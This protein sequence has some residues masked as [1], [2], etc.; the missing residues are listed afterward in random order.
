MGRTAVSVVFHAWYW[1]YL[2]YLNTY[3]ETQRTP[4]GVHAEGWRRRDAEREGIGRIGQEK[5]KTGMLGYN[6]SGVD[7]PH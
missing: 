2:S 6:F 5:G 4:H 3:G 1:Y 7:V